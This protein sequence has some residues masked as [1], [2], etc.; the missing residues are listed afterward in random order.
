[1]WNKYQKEYSSPFDD[2]GNRYKN[3]TFEVVAYSWDDEKE[4]PYN[5]RW[6]NKKTGKPL[7]V[8]WYKYLGRG[9]SVNRKVSPA[10]IEMMLDECLESLEKEDKLY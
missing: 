5:F 7:E 8:S 4:Q 3:E 10:E 9:T 6:V 1:M 2:T